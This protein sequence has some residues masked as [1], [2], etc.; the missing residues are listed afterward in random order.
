MTDLE[1]LVICLAI[2]VGILFGYVY[3]TLM[4]HKVSIEIL[5]QR[6]SKLERSKEK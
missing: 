4:N 6:I 5:A 2:C 1:I 3:G